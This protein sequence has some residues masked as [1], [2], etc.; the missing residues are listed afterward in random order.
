MGTV[1]ARCAD[2]VV[3]TTD[4]PRG[5]DPLAIIADIARGARGARTTIEPDRARAIALAVDMARR[6][7]VVLIAGKGHE[8]Y[9]DIG[10][11]RRPFSDAAVVAR[12]LR[13]NRSRSRCQ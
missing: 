8:Q 3:V 9:Q 6:G 5:E 11:V 12:V 10:G 2:H 4:N 1:A 13:K 7:D